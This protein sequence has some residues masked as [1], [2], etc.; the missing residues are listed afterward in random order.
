MFRLTSPRQYYFQTAAGE[1][2]QLNIACRVFKAIVIRCFQIS[3]TGVWHQDHKNG[4]AE[5]IAKQA[6][7]KTQGMSNDEFKD[8]CGIPSVWSTN[9][10]IQRYMTFK[11]EEADKA[12]ADAEASKAPQDVKKADELK[13]DHLLMTESL[14]VWEQEGGWC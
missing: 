2:S 14:T 1:S 5:Y 8:A 4:R 12:I 10:L 13:K 3:T 9:N 7:A 6:E 11:K